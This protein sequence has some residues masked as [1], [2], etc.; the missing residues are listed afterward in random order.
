[1][2]FGKTSAKYTL[3]SPLSSATDLFIHLFNFHV[4]QLNDHQL[5]YPYFVLRQNRLKCQF[6]NSAHYQNKNSF[7]SLSIADRRLSH[8]I[9]IETVYLYLD[10]NLYS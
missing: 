4:N 10:Q 1:M 6:W 9:S 8:L 7:Q 3:E 2:Q 5:T